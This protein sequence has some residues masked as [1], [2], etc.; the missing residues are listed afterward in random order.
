LGLW[1]AYEPVDDADAEEEAG[2]AE[3]G[4]APRGH[5][6]RQQRL[7][8][9]R[10]RHYRSSATS[11]ASS[12]S[13]G[14]GWESAPLPRL[15]CLLPANAVCVPPVLLGLGPQHIPLFEQ[16]F[17]GVGSEIYGA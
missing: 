13:N 2:G 12:R 1:K 16:S 3:R 6:R 11:D 15:Q 9:P 17:D 5:A 14:E 4:R 10:R 8:R 7:V